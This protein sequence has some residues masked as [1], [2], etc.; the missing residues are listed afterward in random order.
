MENKGNTELV[1]KAIQ[2]I[3]KVAGRRTSERFAD[4]TIKACINS[5]ANKYEFLKDITLTDHVTDD[6]EKIIL[7]HSNKGSMLLSYAFQTKQEHCC[8]S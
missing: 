4:E 8:F 6:R 5:L 2:S 7:I 3:Y 1:K